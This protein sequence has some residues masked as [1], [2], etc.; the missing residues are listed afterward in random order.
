MVKYQYNH[1][2]GYKVI[3]G[4]LEVLSI[5]EST[6]Y[7]MQKQQLQKEVYQA[8]VA[9]TRRKLIKASVAFQAFKAPYCRN[10]KQQTK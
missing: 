7:K 1:Q 4:C 9:R 8:S 5:C 10:N 2:V 6:K 3:N